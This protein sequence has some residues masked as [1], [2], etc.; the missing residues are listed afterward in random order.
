M[1]GVIDWVRRHR[2]EAAALA[3]GLALRLF[4][5]QAKSLWVDEGLSLLTARA[6]AREIASLVAGLQGTPPLYFYLLHGWVRAFSDSVYAL[7]SFSV[8]CG[9]ATLPVFAL[10]ARKLVPK[11]AALAVFLAVCSSFWISISQ[12]AKA[13]ALYLLL[14]VAQ[15]YLL[16]LLIRRWSP[17]T[18]A[19]YSLAA[20]LG[21]YTHVYVLFPL[22]A[23]FLYPVVVLRWDRRRLLPWI[24]A[25]LLIALSF[26]PWLP[27]LIRQLQ[28]P[29]TAFPEP[30][31]PGRLAHMIGLLF[32]DV[33]Y[34]DLAKAAWLRA[35]GAGVCAALGA[36]LVLRWRAG[37]LTREGPEALCVFQVAF[38]LA[39]TGLAEALVGKPMTQARYLVC[40]S[41]WL[42]LLVAELADGGGAWRRALRLGFAAL[43]L[44][45]AVG[46]YACAALI[47]PRL[48][49]LSL[50]LRAAGR[51]GDVVVHLN[52][53]YYVPLR[54]HYLPEFRH[55]LLC[56]EPRWVNWEALPGY[57]AVIGAAELARGGSCVAVDPQRRLAPQGLARVGCRQLA[58][59]RCD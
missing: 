37:R 52:Q 33:F 4:M 42:Y 13:Y 9:V 49:E 23:Q 48:G 20:S 31:T 50:R 11:Q 46:H 54:Y 15:S 34:L 8:L 59:I 10:L 1:A 38:I 36:G 57:P 43:V 6:P 55:R 18:L 12:D 7:R 24:G 51:P 56:P 28:T 25:H 41:P 29:Y 2:V 35:V 3:A 5:L 58:R 45:G 19:A 40:L 47:D 22:A 32:F 30:L 26:A 27:P 39:A 17:R 44:A 21:L 16:A 14:C 53:F